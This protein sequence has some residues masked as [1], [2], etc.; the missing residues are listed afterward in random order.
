MRWSVGR[1][2]GTPVPIH[3][4]PPVPV[5][6]GDRNGSA[7]ATAGPSTSRPGASRYRSSSMSGLGQRASPTKRPAASDRVAD[8]ACQSSMKARITGSARAS[9]AK[10]FSQWSHQRRHS[11]RKSIPGP[12]LP[13]CG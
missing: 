10:P 11:P 1:S 5:Q 12:G 13:S 3:S 8:G 6:G 9:V 4:P 7:A 2:P